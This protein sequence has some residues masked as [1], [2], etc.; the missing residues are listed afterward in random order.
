M[1]GETLA[2]GMMTLLTGDGEQDDDLE[3][4]DLEEEEV[5]QCLSR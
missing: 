1:E 4:D 2:G 5:K 3:E